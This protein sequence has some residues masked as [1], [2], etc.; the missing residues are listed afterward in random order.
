MY[1]AAVARMAAN[2]GVKDIEP[3]TSHAAADVIFRILF[4]ILIEDETATAVF[5]KFC[6]H[7]RMQPILN[8][9]AFIPGLRWMPRFF[10]RTTKSTARDIRRLIT[11]LTERRMFEIDGGTAPEDLATKTMMTADPVTC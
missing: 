11:D 3:V 6:D 2:T 8:L 10:S 1:A 9:R 5:E 4:S 7:Q